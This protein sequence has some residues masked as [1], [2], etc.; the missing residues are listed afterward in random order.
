MERRKGALSI[1]TVL[2]LGGTQRS[3][4][5]DRRPERLRWFDAIGI[6]SLVSGLIEGESCFAVVS[7]QVR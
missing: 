2:S 4:D 7:F 3:A 6:V 5:A 1:N